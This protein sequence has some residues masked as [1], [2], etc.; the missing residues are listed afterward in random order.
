[1]QPL[2]LRPFNLPAMP[3]VY[4][5]RHDGW[6]RSIAGREFGVRATRARSSA[7]VRHAVWRTFVVMNGSGRCR[8]LR[9]DM[10]T[11]LL[12]A[13]LLGIILPA[14]AAHALL[15]EQAQ[16]E[17]RAEA[18]GADPSEQTLG[19]YITSLRDFD[20]AGDSFGADYWV[21]SVHPPETDPLDAIEFVNAKQVDIRLDRT[22][23]RSEGFWSRQK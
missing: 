14:P 13:V 5:E 1:M 11:C 7:P 10:L 19:V 15:D 17:G 18:T 22:T 9:R 2:N 21:W 3:F 4:R 23:E 16:K 20:V 6:Q 8:G 12:A